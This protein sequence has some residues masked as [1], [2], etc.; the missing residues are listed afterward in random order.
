MTASNEELI[1]G[2]AFMSHF[3]RRA[4]SPC[5]FSFL[6][7]MSIPVNER[8]M[9]HTWNPWLAM[10]TKCLPAPQPRSRAFDTRPR[11]SD[12]IEDATNSSGSSGLY[13][14]LGSIWS[15]QFIEVSSQFVSDCLFRLL[16]RGLNHFSASAF[17]LVLH[18]LLASRVCR[19]G[20]GEGKV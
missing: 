18:G 9:P 17:G 3:T 12:L 6:L 16:L 4:S 10:H 2:N 8:S 13:S 7:A 15:Q 19:S 11:F 14:L 5:S 20:C 1:N